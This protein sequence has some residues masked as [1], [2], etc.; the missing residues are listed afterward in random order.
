MTDD[1]FD[2]FSFLPVQAA[3]AGVPA[4]AAER[5]FTFMP[6]GRPLSALRL[7][8]GAPEV[9][10]LHGAGLNAH[11]WDRTV[12]AL[13]RPALALDL[14]GHGDSGWRDDA[15]Y[16]ARTLAADIAP[17]VAQW[18]GTPQ[19]VVGQSLGGLTAAA[20][21]AAHPELVRALVIVD[22]APGLDPAGGAAQIR[23]FFAGPTHWTSRDEM[24]ERA[25]SFGLGGDRTAAERGVFLNSRV[26]EDG[27]VEW[28]HH[29]ARIAN[30][31]AADPDAA[32]AASARQD[33]LAGI[34]AASGWD[35][36]AAVTAPVTLVR[37][38]RGYLSD[39]DLAAFT[40][41][42]PDAAVVT[43]DSGH[44]VQEELPIELAR[45]IRDAAIA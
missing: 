12:L 3:E 7:G 11:T 42:L 41:R 44:N 2:E 17:A 24:V 31:L 36:L 38:T 20:L 10:L 27:R 21:A 33:S 8:D 16:T 25:L 6:D 5:L 4:P 40:D 15:D 14:P 37:G 45:I 13:G 19:V 32:A 1:T 23:R 28:K 9:T 26:R 35:D 18:V 34:L 22:I 30:A 29:F 39:A 43:V